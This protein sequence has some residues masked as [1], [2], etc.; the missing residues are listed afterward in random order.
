MKKELVEFE[1]EE[2]EERRLRE[3]VE[4]NED[5]LL[6]AEIRPKST[7]EKVGHIFVVS[8]ELPV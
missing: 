1:K 7:P 8:V 3:I 4:N 6:V 5:E 2:E